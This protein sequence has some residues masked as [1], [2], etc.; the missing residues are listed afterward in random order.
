VAQYEFLTS[1]CFDA[2]IERV[3]GV[4]NDTAAF[5]EWWKG[6]VAVAVLEPGDA[7]GVGELASY[8]WRGVLPYSLGFESR[9][10]RVEP[11]YLIEGHATGELEGVGIWRLFAGPDGTAVLY[12]WRVRLTKPWMRMWGPLARPAMRWNHDHV[13]RQGG[14]GLAERLGASLLL[15]N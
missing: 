1:W 10:V 11:P 13:M 15:N 7:D 9:V 2:P 8:S 3:F 5:P 14:L 12:S 6:V 4:L